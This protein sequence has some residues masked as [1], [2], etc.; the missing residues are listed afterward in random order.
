MGQPLIVSGPFVGNEFF[1]PV[2]KPH[3]EVILPT[4]EDKEE[5]I[6]VKL[7]A[8]EVVSAGIVQNHKIIFSIISSFVLLTYIFSM[9]AGLI[10]INNHQAVIASESKLATAKI[11]AAKSLSRHHQF[12]SYVNKIENQ[13]INLTVNGSTIAIPAT[14]ISTFIN[15]DKINKNKLSV[16]KDAVNKYLNAL[17]EKYSIPAKSRVVIEHEDGTTAVI[18]PGANGFKVD[19]AS[20]AQAANQLSD[21]LLSGNGSNISFNGVGIPFNTDSTPA[22]YNFL[23]E[24]NVVTKRM[25]A[26]QDGN[27]VRTFLITAGAASTPT[28]IG[29]FTVWQKVP[30]TDMRGI[31]PNGTKYFQPHV[32]WVLYFDHRGDAVHGNYWR[33]ASVFGNVNTSHGCLGVNDTDAEWIYNW[34]PVGTTVVTHA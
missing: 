20:V 14:D 4:Y 5:K 23:L 7:A 10:L 34:A 21:Q 2:R 33:P 28:P 31:N 8:D 9:L 30:Y 15:K 22:G 16:N 18:S 12:L 26:Y 13:P 32:N 25:Y 29:S 3:V 19:P 11:L 24:A 6:E 27:L 17:A 1:V